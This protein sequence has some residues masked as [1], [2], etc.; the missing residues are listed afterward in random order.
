M[1][2]Q[3]NFRCTE[4]SE[5]AENLHVN[6]LRNTVSHPATYYNIKEAAHF[7][8]YHTFCGCKVDDEIVLLIPVSVFYF[9]I[10]ILQ[11]KKTKSFSAIV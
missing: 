11:Q 4:S 1:Q 8:K 5:S 2:S 9:S 3:H 6:E 10:S 7:I